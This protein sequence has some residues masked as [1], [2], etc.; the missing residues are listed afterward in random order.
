MASPSSLADK[1]HNQTVNFIS[2]PSGCD[3]ASFKQCLLFT[4]HLGLCKYFPLDVTQLTE[5]VGFRMSLA[6]LP[7][8]SSSCTK[9]SLYELA[10][11]NLHSGPCREAGQL[12][13]TG[14]KLY[15]KV[16]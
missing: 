3:G 10:W 8:G 13:L 2:F 4:N 12:A 15:G 16:N 5:N 9:V 14:H 11:I 7:R 6:P 1:L